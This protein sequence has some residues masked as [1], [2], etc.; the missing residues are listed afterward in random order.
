VI[1]RNGVYEALMDY[2]AFLGTGDLPGMELPGI[3]FV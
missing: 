3:D 1:V 2:G